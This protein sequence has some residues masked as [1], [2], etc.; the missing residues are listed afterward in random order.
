[1][2][3]LIN[4]SVSDGPGNWLHRSRVLGQV[5][6]PLLEANVTNNRLYLQL[7]KNVP[8]LYASKVRYEN[9]PA[10]TFQGQ[11]VEE[12]ALIPIV[13]ARGWGDC[14]DLSPWRVS[15]LQEHGE[16]AKIRIQW[17]REI[18]PNGKRG[19]KYFHIVVRRGDGRT[20]EDPSALLGMHERMG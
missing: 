3:I 15:E 2:Q 12:F 13:I 6:M 11:P 7:H 1:M 19:R 17:K 14:D 5:I 18:F 16:P 4:C 8:A 10:W 9:E 20:I